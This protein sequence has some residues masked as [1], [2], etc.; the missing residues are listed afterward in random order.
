MGREARVSN[1]VI[2][3][4]MVAMAAI[5][6]GGILWVSNEQGLERLGLLFAL[7]GTCLA[8]LTAALRSDQAAGRLNGTLDAR[9]HDAVLKANQTRR[10][11]DAD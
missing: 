3:A 6:L 1:K 2:V 5:G 7:L 11:G 4:A 9:I 10:A 8:S